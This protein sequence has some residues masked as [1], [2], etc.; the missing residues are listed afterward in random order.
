[1]RDISLDQRRTIRAALI[2][3]TVKRYGTTHPNP[4]PWVESIPW[5]VTTRD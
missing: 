5:A 4:Q 3:T 2:P 1:M